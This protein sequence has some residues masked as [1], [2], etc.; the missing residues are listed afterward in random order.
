MWEQWEQK[1]QEGVR[2]DA[3]LAE[4][5]AEISLILSKN[6]EIMEVNEKLGN[7]LKVCQKHQE[8]VVRVNKNMEAEIQ[9]LKETNL[10]AISKLQEP[11]SNLSNQ[12]F[13]NPPTYAKWTMS[14]RATNFD[15]GDFDRKSERAWW[16]LTFTMR[17]TSHKPIFWHSI[18]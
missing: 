4:A 8:N 1:R 5:T 12:P 6:N 10:K 13:P 15:T 3:H 2:I 9:G 11:F 7:D 18:I 14:S 16:W 17:H